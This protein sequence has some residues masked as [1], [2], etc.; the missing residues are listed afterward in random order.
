M[1]GRSKAFINHGTIDYNV[2]EDFFFIVLGCNIICTM[3]VTDILY[4]KMGIIYCEFIYQAL[5]GI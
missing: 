2:F 1:V 3:Y 4:L 5:L